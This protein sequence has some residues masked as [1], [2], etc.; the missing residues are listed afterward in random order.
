MQKNKVISKSLLNLINAKI[1]IREIE[2][3]EFKNTHND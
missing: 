1:W 3:W 2:V